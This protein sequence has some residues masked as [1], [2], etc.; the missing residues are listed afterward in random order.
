M[1]NVCIHGICSPPCYF[2]SLISSRNPRYDDHNLASPETIL[3]ARLL[4]ASIRNYRNGS[5]SEDKNHIPGPTECDGCAPPRFEEHGR[6]SGR[7]RS[8]C[9]TAPRSNPAGLG[10]R[11]WFQ[12]AVSL[13]LQLR[14]PRTTANDT[15]GGGLYS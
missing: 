3:P 11:L 9:H 4:I 14:K 1:R 12:C 13:S 8:G 6:L 5:K 2:Q 10:R 15:S 7:Y